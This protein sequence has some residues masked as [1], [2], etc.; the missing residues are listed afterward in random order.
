MKLRIAL[1]FFLANISFCCKQSQPG[2]EISDDYL[3][4][5]I[6]P[7]SGISPAKVL[8]VSQQLKEIYPHINIKPAIN[9]PPAAYFPG[10]N[11]YRADSILRYLKDL[12]PK[13]H[14]CLGLTVKDISTTNGEVKDWGIMGLGYR[15]GKACVVSSFRLD[16]R[17]IDAQFFKVCIHEVGHTQGLDHCPIPT[18]F[19]RDAEGGNPINEEKEFCGKCRQVL[20]GKG[21]RFGKT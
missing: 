18:C 2:K 7:F 9:L 10:R 5:D 8:L 1:I 14:V 12:T 20:V 15:P 11:R 21:W 19:M 13:G 16:K 6:Q 4:I 3:I 17:N